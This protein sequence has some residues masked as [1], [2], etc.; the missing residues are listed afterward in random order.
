MPDQALCVGNG[1]LVEMVSGGYV[2]VR[3]ASAPACDEPLAQYP[4]DRLFGTGKPGGFSN[5]RCEWR[6]AGGRAD[7]AG[8]GPRRSMQ[9]SLGRAASVVRRRG[10]AAAAALLR[11][12]CN[13]HGRPTSWRDRPCR[14]SHHAMQPNHHTPCDLHLQP[15]PFAGLYDKESK[16]F[17]FSALYTS[18]KGNTKIHVAV[19]TCSNPLG[20]FNVY[21]ADGNFAGKFCNNACPAPDGC[22][23]HYLTLGADANGIW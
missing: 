2:T 5:P 1:Y 18:C 6:P 19:S 8:A 23:S 22:Q 15:P 9:P 10:E 11:H 20:P 3:N 7:G 17:V 16:R 12:R 14:P 4:L 21:D 13:H